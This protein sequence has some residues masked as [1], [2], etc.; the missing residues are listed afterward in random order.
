MNRRRFEVA[1]RLFRT[2][3]AVDVV[4]S[5]HSIEAAVSNIIT[6]RSGPRSMGRC[7]IDDMWLCISVLRGFHHGVIGGG[8]G[9]MKE[10]YP[11][12]RKGYFCKS[13]SFVG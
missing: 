2:A 3:T 8:G 13:Y 11:P 7:A 4:F 5:S 6:A 1:A 12:P 10:K 9:G